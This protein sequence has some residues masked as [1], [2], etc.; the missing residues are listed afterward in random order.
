MAESIIGQGTSIVGT[1]TGAGDL[2]LEGR[3]EGSVQVSGDVE[4]G[5]GS[6]VKA[7]VSGRSVT[8]RGAVAGAISADD[9]IVLETGARVVGD[10]S[11]PRVGIRPGGLLKG[12]VSTDGSGHARP[13][14]RQRAEAKPAAAA[15]SAPARPSGASRSAPE[16]PTVSKSNKATAK[17]ASSKAPTRKKAPPAATI[18]SA[19][20]KKAPPPVVPALK[21]GAKGSV[22]RR[23]H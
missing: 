6:L 20:G 2:R 3:L 5:D 11:A 16:M 8:V 19:R 17:A 15:R 1:V 13:R 10:L 12:Y 9:S 14:E 7:P 23:G 4:L 22:K 21:K 18:G